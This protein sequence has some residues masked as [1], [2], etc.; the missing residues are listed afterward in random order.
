MKNLSL[1]TL[2][3]CASFALSGIAYAGSPV[4]KTKLATTSASYPS[5]GTLPNGK[6]YFV[7][8]GS[9]P[10]Y[11]SFFHANG[12]FIAS[13][14]FS[15]VGTYYFIAYPSKTDTGYLRVEIFTSSDTINFLSEL[16]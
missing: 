16:P 11:V 1:V 3:V 4:V 15:Q 14:N 8:G 5:S 6:T 12:G 9:T 7:Y 10:Q 2:L 13:Y